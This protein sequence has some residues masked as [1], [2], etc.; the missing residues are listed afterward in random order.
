MDY[1]C[2]LY[3]VRYLNMRKY[4]EDMCVCVCVNIEYFHINVWETYISLFLLV[5]ALS[6]ASWSFKLLI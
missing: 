6:E 4:K 2:T 3:G 5:I 1:A